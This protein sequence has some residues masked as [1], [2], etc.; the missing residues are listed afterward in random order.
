MIQQVMAKKMTA[1]E[2]CNQ[3]ADLMTKMKAEDD[4]EISSGASS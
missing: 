4:A 3:W 1:Q 2:L